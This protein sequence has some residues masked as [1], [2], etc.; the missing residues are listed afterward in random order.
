M[1]RILLPVPPGFHFQSTVTSHG[2]C[3]LPPFGYDD[4]ART[5]TRV[6]RLAD[7]SSVHLILGGDSDDTTVTVD[8]D[9]LPLPPTPAQV[10]DTT[11]VVGRILG[12]DQNIGEFHALT[13]TMPGYE[14]IEPAG[15]GRMLV[16]PTVW[17]DLAKTLLTT[18]TTWRMTK[19]MVARLVTLGEADAHGRH[20]FPTPAQVAALSPEALNAH[21]RAGYR[22][23]SLHTLADSIATGRLDP[24]RWRDPA[25][26]ARQV[27]DEI[28][29]LKGFGPYAAGAMMRLVGHFDELGL[30]SVCRAAYR[31]RWN[32]G[33]P[34]TDREIAAFYERFGRWR[35]LA[36]WMDVMRDELLPNGLQP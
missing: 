23:A 6:Q 14:W 13:R 1:T 34:A 9:G 3:V 35:G 11:A 32:N 20:S 21:V 17:E 27:Y 12:F 15:A 26:S 25:M 31:E 8:I 10:G 36:V 28:L 18:N 30:D 5:L 29:A 2:W 24:E 7:G 19:E 16:S 4:A 22:G 33:E